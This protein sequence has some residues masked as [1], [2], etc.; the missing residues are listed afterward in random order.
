MSR[1]RKAQLS[2]VIFANTHS[3]WPSENLG[4]GKQ[5]ESASVRGV[6]SGEVN[7][8]SNKQ[9]LGPLLT[10]PRDAELGLTEHRIEEH[11]GAGERHN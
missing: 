6:V 3:L 10:I 5:L 8:A 2:A 7:P 1:E 4:A 11:L 9:R